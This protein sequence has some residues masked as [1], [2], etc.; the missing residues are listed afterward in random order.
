[1]KLPDFSQWQDSLRDMDAP[2]RQRL[3]I[4]VTGIVV[5]LWVGNQMLLAPLEKSWKARSERIAKLRQQLAAGEQ[6]LQR[7]SGVRGQTG[8]RAE[9]QQMQSNALP[10][11]VSQ[12]EGKMLEAFDRWSRDSQ[13]SVTSV[14]PQWKR[15]DDNYASLEC[16]VD[17]T[18]SLSAITR[19]LYEIEHDSLAMKVDIVELNS[20]DSTGA[21]LGLSLQVNGLVLNPTD[22]LTP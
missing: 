5:G 10:S 6:L 16:R 14:K 4:I 19:F 20:R 1:M 22:R 2:A 9:W 12:A 21:Q 7:E 3:L 17:A 11:S 8:L 13:I 15:N 18:G